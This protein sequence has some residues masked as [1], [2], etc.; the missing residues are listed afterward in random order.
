MFVAAI[1]GIGIEH[2]VNTDGMRLALRRPFLWRN[3]LKLNA[4]L[5]TK[6]V[7][8]TWKSLVKLLLVGGTEAA[9]DGR[10]TVGW[11]ESTSEISWQH[12]VS[13]MSDAVVSYE[14]YVAFLHLSTR[15]YWV[16]TVLL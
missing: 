8:F 11:V 5:N 10:K 15:H 12:T 9:F 14:H 4:L 16:I 2:R 13:A 7:M 3:F 1:L 6:S